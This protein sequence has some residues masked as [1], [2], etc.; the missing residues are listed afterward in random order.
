MVRKDLVE[1]IK[2]AKEEENSLKDAMMSF[3]LAGYKKEDI[4]EAAKIAVKEGKERKKSQEK[5]KISKYENEKKK[6]TPILLVVLIVLIVILIIGAGILLYF[7][8]K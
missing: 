3:Y 6:N 2:R 7:L 8:M 4:E 5:N 1:G